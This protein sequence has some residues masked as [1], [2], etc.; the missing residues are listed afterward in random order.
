MVDSGDLKSQVYHCLAWLAKRQSFFYFQAILQQHSR[1][2]DHVKL[3]SAVST[4]SSRSS[5]AVK[6]IEA[7]QDQTMNMT[8]DHWEA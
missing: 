5:V 6:L 1:S 7:E 4:R 3:F 2:S 8:W